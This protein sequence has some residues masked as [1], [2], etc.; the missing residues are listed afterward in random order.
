MA[1]RIYLVGEQSFNVAEMEEFLRENRTFWRKTPQTTPAEQIVEAAGRIC[2]MS[3][4]EKQSPRD[5]HEYMRRLVEQGH[6]SVL[7]HVSWCFVITGVS[8]AFTHQL[9]RHRVGFSF[10][11]LSQQYHEETDA[12]FI[13]P[14]VELPPEA[15]AAWDGAMATARKAYG[16]ILDSLRFLESKAKRDDDC[17]KEVRRAIRSTARSV[18]PNATQTKIWVTANARA[19]R[20]F[21]SVRG[22]LVGD[23]EMREVSAEILRL[24]KPKAPSLFFDF[25]IEMLPDGTPIVIRKTP[26]NEPAQVT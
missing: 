15:R 7:E 21:F 18:L 1:P 25:E 24:V 11:Q 4:G 19:L 13:E 20:H 23:L 16:E 14:H 5:T 10:S 9:V 6:E 8:R 26:S 12:E 22:N 17:L 2:Y 3:F